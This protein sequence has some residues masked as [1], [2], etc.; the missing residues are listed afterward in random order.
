MKR[1]VKGLAKSVIFCFRGTI[2][3]SKCLQGRLGI[4]KNWLISAYVLVDGTLAKIAPQTFL[5]VLIQYICGIFAF[6]KAKK[7]TFSFFEFVP[8]FGHFVIT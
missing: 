6:G 1:D 4:K 3:L 2:Y 8:R 7:D 5:H